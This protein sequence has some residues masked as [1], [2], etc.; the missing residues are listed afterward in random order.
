MDELYHDDYIYGNET[1]C[2]IFSHMCKDALYTV[3]LDNKNYSILLT[4][5]N[6]MKFPRY[7]S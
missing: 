4:C 1:F 6:F 3:S 7:M 5:L 2:P